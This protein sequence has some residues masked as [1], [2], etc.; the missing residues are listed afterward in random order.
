MPIGVDNYGNDIYQYVSPAFIHVE[1]QGLNLKPSDRK[2][3]FLSE[4]YN[5]SDVKYDVVTVPR[6]MKLDNGDLIDITTGRTVTNAMYAQRKKKGDMTLYDVFG[7]QKVKYT[8]GSPI[9]TS[10]MEHVYKLVNLYGDGQYGSEYYSTFKPSEMNNGTV[11][12][13]NEIPDGD[14]IHFF[15]TKIEGQK[16]KP[17]SITSEEKVKITQPINIVNF[18]VQYSYQVVKHML[19]DMVRKL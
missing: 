18:I 19:K 17:A 13:D 7:Y 2:I 12:I 6:I 8:D 11:K 14:I 5:A 3:L 10:K 4:I 15:G 1:L 16:T 9:V